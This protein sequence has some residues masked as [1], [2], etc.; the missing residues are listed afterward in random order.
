VYNADETG[1]N[2]LQTPGYIKGQKKKT[3]SWERGRNK[4]VVV[5][6]CK[7]H[8]FVNPRKNISPSLTV[9]IPSH[10]THRVQPLDL[11]FFGPLKVL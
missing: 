8:M 1:I 4:A 11:T 5:Q 7:T 3:G 6:C 9:L 2:T 10:T